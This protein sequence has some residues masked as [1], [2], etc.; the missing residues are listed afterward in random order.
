LQKPAGA[1]DLINDRLIYGVRA[2]L[3]GTM[4]L[5]PVSV[6]GTALVE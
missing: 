4:G 1:I 5:E 3:D 2:T 6:P